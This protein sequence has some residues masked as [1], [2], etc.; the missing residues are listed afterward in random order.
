[1]SSDK[2]NIQRVKEGLQTKY[3]R[4]Y[5]E[6]PFHDGSKLSVGYP[7]TLEG[8]AIINKTGKYYLS[9]INEDAHESPLI[10]ITEQDFAECQ[11]ICYDQMR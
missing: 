6:Y 8:W 4:F 11:R 9:H 3:I 2:L 5:Q 10:P 1:M 7:A